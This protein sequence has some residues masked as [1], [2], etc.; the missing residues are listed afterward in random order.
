MRPLVAS[1]SMLR[2]TNLATGPSVFCSAMGTPNLAQY[3]RD[4]AGPD[5]TPL[6]S[7]P[8]GNRLGSAGLLC[9]SL[10]APMPGHL[11]GH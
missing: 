8:A 11:P 5:H 7:P 2:N 4:P 6:A 1:S 3:V 9:L 10:K